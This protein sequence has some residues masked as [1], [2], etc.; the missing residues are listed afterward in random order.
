[1]AYKPSI[2]WY[3]KWYA[4]LLRLYSQPFHRRFGEGMEQ[5]FGD[6]LQDRA[7]DGRG[8]LGYA[9]RMFVETSTEII[10]ERTTV[11]V[12]R[13]K[14]IIGV[15]LAAAF[16]LLLPLLAMRGAKEVVWSLYDFA[17]AGALL[18]GTGLMYALVMRAGGT[19]AYRAA[20][21]MAVTGT[22]FLVWINLAVGIIGSENNPF[23]LLYF[24]VVA[25]G[26][27]GAYTVRFKPD[28]MSRVLLAMAIAQTA[29]PAIALIAGQ[30]WPASARGSIA[31]W[32]VNAL[33]IVLFTGSA[34]LFR[35]AAAPA[36]P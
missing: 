4:I 11:M 25:A 15:A 18:F 17:I 36:V 8:L 24:G 32:G 14:G 33:F 21:C 9:L 35:R 34:L 2:R 20:A 12:M 27:C 6:L 19:S 13:N 7:E 1:M 29:V 31:V 10:R 28:G 30:P 5:T 23:N 26:I 16:I 3:R 22:F